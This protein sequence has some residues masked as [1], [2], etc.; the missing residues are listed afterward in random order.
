M[1]CGIGERFVRKN[2]GTVRPAMSPR[3]KARK[4]KL[5]MNATNDSSS[6]LSSL[7]DWAQYNCNT[8]QTH[9]STLITYKTRL[10]PLHELITSNNWQNCA[11]CALN[12]A[13]FQSSVSR[14]TRYE[15]ARKVPAYVAT[16]FL[17]EIIKYL[18]MLMD[19][20]RREGSIQTP[21]RLHADDYLRPCAAQ[22]RN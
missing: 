8:L 15:I 10:Q 12:V 2:H 7:C 17:V 5:K 19:W 4:R 3:A 20:K 9:R 18:Y 1:H 22:Q 14:L 21:R 6:A 11:E 13:F 16:F